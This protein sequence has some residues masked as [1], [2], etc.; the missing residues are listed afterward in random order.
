MTKET[1]QDVVDSVI[2]RSCAHCM[3]DIFEDPDPQYCE[4]CEQNICHT[5]WHKQYPTDYCLVCDTETDGSQ[6]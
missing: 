2:G 3:K 1:V 6:R 4:H 5:C